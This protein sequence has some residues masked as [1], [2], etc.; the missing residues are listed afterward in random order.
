MLLEKSKKCYIN[1]KVSVTQNEAT[2][3]LK[4]MLPFKG[5]F[6]VLQIIS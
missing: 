5:R 6:L 2:R 4:I 1:N 3:S